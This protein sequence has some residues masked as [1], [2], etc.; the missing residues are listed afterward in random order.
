MGVFVAVAFI[1]TLVAFVVACVAFIGPAVKLFVACVAFEFFGICIMFSGVFMA[2]FGDPVA[3][4]NW[5]EQRLQFHNS[6]ESPEFQANTVKSRYNGFK[7]NAYKRSK[8]PD[9]AKMRP[10]CVL[11]CIDFGDRHV[12][13]IEGHIEGRTDR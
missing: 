10:Y 1:D 6:I 7:S 9:R 2:F 3:T 11:A 8:K 4:R 5:E 12:R 13:Y